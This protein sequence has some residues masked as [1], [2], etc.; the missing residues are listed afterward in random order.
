M[1][2][3]CTMRLYYF[4]CLAVVSAWTECQAATQSHTIQFTGGTFYGPGSMPDVTSPAGKLSGLRLS[5]GIAGEIENVSSAAA[6]EQGGATLLSSGHPFNRNMEGGTVEVG[7]GAMR[8]HELVAADGPGAGKGQLRL[9]SDLRWHLVV[10]LVLDPGFPEG[11]VSING[12]DITSAAV[13]V[14]VSLQTQ[15]GIAGGTDRA[16]SLASGV[17]VVGHLGDD[18]GDGYLDGVIVGAT[19]MPLQHMFLPGAPTVQVRSFTTDIPIAP[20]DALLLSVSSALTYENVFNRLGSASAATLPARDELQKRLLGELEQRLDA[21][22]RNLTRT[23]GSATYES[24][25]QTA[26]TKLKSCG[27]AADPPAAGGCR[28]E[29]GEAFRHLHSLQG[30]LLKTTALR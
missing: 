15:G 1:T 28:G 6:Q 14:P 29:L 25:L 9:D 24:D 10:D 2:T 12:L 22:L 13:W 8:F 7:R 5:V 27:A 26:Q 20:R 23:P 3:G 17:P 21:A 18:D 19:N 30:R 4:A 16:G 11:L